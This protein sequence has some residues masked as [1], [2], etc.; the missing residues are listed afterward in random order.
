MGRAGILYSDV[1][2]AA[3]KLVEAGENP[4]VDS[5]RLA[6]GNTG[7]KSTIAPM[8]KQWKGEHQKKVSQSEAGLPPTLLS[9]VKGLYQ[10]M[11]DEFAQQLEQARQ[12]HADALRSAIESE[13][14]A[15]AEAA[16]TGAA[17]IGLMAELESARQALEQQLAAHHAQN[18]MVATVQ[19][20]NAGL[21]QR[22][23]DRAAEV[24]TL[25]H[26]LA[27]TRAQFEHFQEASASQ[28]AQERSVA[29]QKISRLEQ[30]L[31]GALRQ[32]ALQHATLSQQQ[33]RLT[34]LTADN[35]TQRTELQA[36]QAAAATLSNERDRFSERLTE[37]A[38]AHRQAL[39]L[40]E[41]LRRQCVETRMT[42]AGHEREARM[43]GTQLQRAQASVDRLSEEKLNWIRERAAL[44]ELTRKE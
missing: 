5:V 33:E 44:E 26:Q 10:H 8:L 43:L 17:N 11:Q 14:R 9:T 3:S 16:A 21:Q 41:T 37:T 36:A 38:A 27:Q 25:G 23:A 30:E 39:E 34:Q 42:L 24:H 20:D 4:T 13:Q 7:S 32:N 15:R 2:K 40:S 22:L 6:L 35:A 19:A 31:A 28:R 1:A 18:V 12:E 29:E